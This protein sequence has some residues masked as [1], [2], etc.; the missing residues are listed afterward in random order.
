M[1]EEG[2][3]RYR[4]A[5]LIINYRGTS[6]IITYKGT[7]LIRNYRGTS[8]I[9]NYRGTSL[10]RNYRGTSLIR[11]YKGTSLIRNVEG[12]HLHGLL[13]GEEAPDTERP[14]HYTVPQSCTERYSSQ[15]KNNCLA[16]MWRAVSR[17]AR[18]QSA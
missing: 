7:S 11:N 15:F 18:L 8:L 5:S 6:L 3:A 2:A 4:G 17:R 9:R 16:E 1:R 14:Q 12:G 13:V 10:M